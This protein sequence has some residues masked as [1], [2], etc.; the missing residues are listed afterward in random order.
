MVTKWDFTNKLI[1]PKPPFF[2]SLQISQ[3]SQR[4]QKKVDVDTSTT[5]ELEE[6]TEEETRNKKRKQ[7]SDFCN[8]CNIKVNLEDI[9]TFAICRG[10]DQT[11]CRSKYCSD[12]DRTTGYWECLTCISNRDGQLRAGEWILDQ[13]NRRFK[14]PSGAGERLANG[15]AIGQDGTATI[16]HRDVETRK[17]EAYYRPQDLPLLHK[18]FIVSESER[19]YPESTY[20][21]SIEQKAKVREFLEEIISEMVGGP[22]DEVPVTQ[23]HKEPE[24]K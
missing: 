10:C 5:G 24:C 15:A 7:Y 18:Y 13:L 8:K 2:F 16:S 6:Q 21:I 11:T 19:S 3:V 14:T 17:R 22:L 9:T 1:N 23:L 4:R 20:S 12:W